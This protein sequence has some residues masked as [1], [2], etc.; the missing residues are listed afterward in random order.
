MYIQRKLRE[1]QQFYTDTLIGKYKL[2][3][4]NTCAQMFANKSF[5]AK[6]YTMEKSFAGAALCQFICNFGVLGRAAHFL[7]AQQSRPSPRLKHIRDYGIDYHITEPHR[8]QQ[9]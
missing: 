8:P 4:N 2:V 1:G 3:T 7:M 5:F 6:A 9:N